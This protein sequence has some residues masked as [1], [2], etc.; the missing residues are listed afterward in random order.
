MRHLGEQQTILE[1]LGFFKGASLFLGYF[2]TFRRGGKPTLILAINSTFLLLLFNKN[3]NNS[4][5][6]CYTKA[7]FAK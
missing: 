7:S 2:K 5:E 6:V 3:Y 1:I 4:Q